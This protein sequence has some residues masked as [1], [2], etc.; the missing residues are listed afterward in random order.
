LDATIPVTKRQ[1]YSTHRSLRADTILS[2]GQFSMRILLVEDNEPLRKALHRM[3]EDVGADIVVEACDG[4]QA[5]QRMPDVR[6][7][8]IV[9]DF[10]MPQMDGIRLTRALR[11]AGIDTPIVMISAMNDPT[12]TKIALEAGV[13]QFLCKGDESEKLYSTFRKIVSDLSKAA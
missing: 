8:L 9:T 4:E 10:Q 12:V 11:A 5:M 1:K 7:N 2:P 6:P 3:L 13:N